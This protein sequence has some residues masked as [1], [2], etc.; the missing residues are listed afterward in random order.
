[1]PDEVPANDAAPQGSFD[2]SGQEVSIVIQ[3]DQFGS[4]TTWDLYDPFNTIVASGGPYASNTTITETLCLPVAPFLNCFGFIIF[5]SFGDGICC[6]YGAGS[7]Q[8]RNSA[9]RPLL[10]DIFHGSATA[11]DGTPVA[12]GDQ[13]PAAALASPGY[14][15]GTGYHTFCL[16]VAPIVATADIETTECGVFTNT[17]QNKVYCDAVAGASDYQ[18]EFSDPDAGFVRRIAVFGRRWVAFSEMQTVP[19]IPGTHYFVRARADDPNGFLGNF[20]DDVFGAG[21]ETGIDPTL[22]PGCTQL[23]DDPSLP[24][25]SCGGTYV[26][27]GSDRVW[28]YPVVGATQYRF[29]FQNPGEGFLR[30]I[31]RPSYVCLLNWFTLP[32]TPAI[33]DVDVN[34]LVNG[35]WG[36]YCGAS[37]PITIV[38]APGNLAGRDLGGQTMTGV[39]LWPN[40]VRDGNVN[41]SIEGLTLSEQRITVDLYDMFGKR[42]LANSYEIAGEVFNA[43]LEVDGLAAGIY[44]AHINTEEGTHIERISVQ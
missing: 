26:F 7:W 34:V 31:A 27:N 2:A 40:P 1:V 30:Q 44:M 20:F 17:L 6:Q 13:S 5:D 36:G 23:I 39:S 37:C 16:P 41:L 43:T 15:D 25:N 32:L 10:G 22:V 38:P 8:I 33:Y 29:R 4:E 21:C 35:Q 9:N 24:T 11:P 19:L 28:A 18:F 14:G 42:V 12:D 3:T